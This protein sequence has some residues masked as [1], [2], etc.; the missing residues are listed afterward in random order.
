MMNSFFPSINHEPVENF[1][2]LYFITLWQ[3]EYKRKF[4]NNLR[5]MEDGFVLRIKL[6]NLKNRGKLKK[7]CNLNLKHK[8]FF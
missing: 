2:R 8:K 7:N 1:F 3:F 5:M 6:N 4:E